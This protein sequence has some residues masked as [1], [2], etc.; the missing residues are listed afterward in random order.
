ME[1]S[2]LLTEVRQEDV[3]ALTVLP[4]AVRLKEDELQFGDS[5]LPINESGRQQLYK[6]INVPSKYLERCPIDL[7]DMNVNAWIQQIEEEIKV[8]YTNDNVVGF[9]KPESVFVPF[10][11]VL[12]AMGEVLGTELSVTNFSKTN[13]DFTYNVELSTP[14]EHEVKAGDAVRTGICMQYSP[15]P[16]VSKKIYTYILRLVCS[17][18][19]RSRER[20]L[21]F[22]FA[23]KSLGEI[24]NDVKDATIKALSSANEKIEVLRTFANFEVDRD[25]AIQGIFNSSDIPARLYNRVLE[26]AQNEDSTMWGVLN[27][28]TAAA[29][30]AGTLKERMSLQEIAGEIVDKGT[31]ECPICSTIIEN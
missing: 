4:L 30:Q 8:C 19:M 1:F 23:G 16:N 21:R 24:T 18:G 2:E 20:G 22:R 15:F 31:H 6:H 13:G 26:N 9:L 27:A 14:E 29:N 5:L 25:H 12:E 17:N 11:P 3:K 28:F 10:Y 7:R